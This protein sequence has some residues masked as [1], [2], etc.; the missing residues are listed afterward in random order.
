[1]P[2]TLLDGLKGLVTPDLLSTASRNLGESEGTVAIGLVASFPTILAGL[3]VKTGSAQAFRPLFDL[4]NNPAHEAV[5]S[6]PR[7]A[8]TATP[9]SPLGMAGGRLLTSLFGS[10]LTSVR[11]VIAHAAGA[12]SGTGASLLSIAAPLVLG[13][14]GRRVRT[15]GLDAVGLSSLL[16]G[17][18]RRIT[19]A[20]PPGLGAIPGLG[21]LLDLTPPVPDARVAAAPPSPSRTPYWHR[22]V[23]VA[24][25]LVVALLGLS[26][27]RRVASVDEAV[28]ALGD[29]STDPG[30]AVAP[31][32]GG[33]LRFRCGEQRVSLSQEGDRTVLT[34][35]AGTFDLRRVESA[36]GAKFEA[37]T[38]GETTFWNKGD[39]ALL[40]INGRPYPECTTAP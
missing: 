31:T 10:Q 6:D 12:S 7:L 1:M 38:D 29:T 24:V 22:P 39:R 18:R 11:E 2:T 32:F 17:E 15:S 20:L 26:R 4:I 40:T 28:G 14:L 13:V 34:A 23:P 25:L 35:D 3:T 9:D 21:P 8:A 27:V 19:H 36:S 33:A 30:E 16:V 37:F 5:T